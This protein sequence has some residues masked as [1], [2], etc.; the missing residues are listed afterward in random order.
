VRWIALLLTCTIACR[1][2]DPSFRSKS[3]ERLSD[4]DP[5]PF[6]VAI[7][8]IESAGVFSGKKTEGQRESLW[9]TFNDRGLQEFLVAVM[10]SNP[11][12]AKQ[13]RIKGL[14]TFNETLA[15]TAPDLDSAVVFAR[16]NHADL[17]IVPRLVEDPVF[18]YKRINGRWA[19]SLALYITWIG[20]LFVQ[21]R[22]YR[23][24]LSFDFAIIN[25]HDG[26]A[27]TTFSAASRSI[28]ADQW[29]RMN[30]QF[31]TVQTAWSLILPAFWVPDNHTDASRSTT[32]RV[33]ARLAAQ[34]TGFLKED[35]VKQART[36]TGTLQGVEPRNGSEQESGK[37]FRF[38]AKIVGTQ[39]ITDIAVYVDD[40]PKPRR[41]WIEAGENEKLPKEVERLPSPRDQ[42]QISVY[43]VPIGVDGLSCEG[44]ETRVRVEFAVNG[45]Y[46]SQTYVYRPAAPAR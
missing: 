27:I 1:A 22:E 5:L 6:R 29:E 40:E 15:V 26:T 28:D 35:Y 4:L 13:Y 2:S 41:E 34:L 12:L 36:L 43:E 3:G 14:R 31:W 30:K 44:K 38:S 25:P 9:F 23:A 16:E 17:L 21:D 20:G 46:A 32:A 24:I 42:S 11:E 37:E 33:C 19:T 7:A 45:R 18:D 10:S 8:K 39:P